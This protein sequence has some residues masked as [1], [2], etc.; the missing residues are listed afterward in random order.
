[1]NQKNTTVLSAC[2]AF[3]QVCSYGSPKLCHY[4]INLI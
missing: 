3:G 1:M 2:P 4:S